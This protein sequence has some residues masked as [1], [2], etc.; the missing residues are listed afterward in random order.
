MDK[1]LLKISYDTGKSMMQMAKEFGCSM[2]KVTYW[3]RKHSIKRRSRS[4]AN[5]LFYNPDGDPFKIKTDLSK[6]EALL[7]GLGLGIYWG[8]GSKFSKHSLR[9]ANTNP[10]IL[11]A[12][13]QFLKTICQL[14]DKRI[15][16]SIVSFN[17][18]SPEVS[19]NYW[20]KELEI[21]PGKFGKITQIPKQGKGTY[22]RKSLYGVCTIQAHNVKLRNWLV[23]ELEDLKY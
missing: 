23:Q 22:K 11:R 5:Y 3:M 13:R 8:E 12:F 10:E 6:H 4:E 19:R 18:V 2:S 9:V 21:S 17:D 15:S 16:Y 7:K 1:S 14:K 20:S